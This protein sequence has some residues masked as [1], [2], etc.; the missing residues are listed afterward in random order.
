MIVEGIN[1]ATE[2]LKANYPV[3]KVIINNDLVKKCDN[4]ISLAKS[5]NVNVEYTSKQD[6]EKLTK[7]RIVKVC[8]VL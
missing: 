5:R 7:V 1:C 6:I 3:E 2:L 8:C 4:I